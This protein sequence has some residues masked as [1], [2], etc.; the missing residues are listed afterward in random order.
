MELLEVLELC[1]SLL[2]LL[3][4]VLFVF[5]KPVADPRS[6]EFLKGAAGQIKAVRDSLNHVVSVGQDLGAYTSAPAPTRARS[7]TTSSPAAPPRTF[8]DWLTEWYNTAKVLREPGIW[9]KGF[10]DF[11]RDYRQTNVDLSAGRRLTSP[12]QQTLRKV[13]AEAVRCSDTDLDPPRSNSRLQSSLGQ[14]VTGAGL[15]FINPAPGTMY[16]PLAA[17]KRG[18]N[19]TEG[20]ARQPPRRKVRTVLT[21]GLQTQEGDIVLDPGMEEAV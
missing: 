4:A 1:L 3:A 9:S 20:A 15:E 8:Y 16:P 21:R 14:L 5:L 6:A 19:P 18:R 17:D 7:R 12:T 2:V 13:A 10:Q 11:L